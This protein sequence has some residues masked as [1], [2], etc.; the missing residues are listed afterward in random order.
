MF[1]YSEICEEGYT[2][3]GTWCVMIVTKPANFLEAMVDC[4]SRGENLA[5]VHSQE[6]NDIIQKLAGYKNVWIGLADFLDEGEFSWVG[7]PGNSRFLNWLDGQPDNHAENE[8]CAH[9]MSDGQWNDAPCKTEFQYVCQ[10]PIFQ[11]IIDK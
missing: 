2:V 4:L 11:I 9:M 10:Q 8:H 7:D 1:P 6:E 3:A 5:T